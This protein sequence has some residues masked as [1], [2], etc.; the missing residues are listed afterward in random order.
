MQCAARGPWGVIL[1]QAFAAWKARDLSGA[2]LRYRIAAELG[3]RTAQVNIGFM[4]E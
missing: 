3:Y 2:Y 1:Q 4:F